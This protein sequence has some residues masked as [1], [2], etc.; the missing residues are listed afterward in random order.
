M[1]LD[2][3][4]RCDL[5]TKFGSKMCLRGPGL[6]R[7]VPSSSLAGEKRTYEGAGQHG[8]HSAEK[9]ALRTGQPMLG[10]GVWWQIRRTPRLSLGR[11]CAFF[12]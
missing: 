5:Y 1:L 2:N 11:R 7:K 4:E 6:E 9:R 8:A 10:V 12:V 3:S